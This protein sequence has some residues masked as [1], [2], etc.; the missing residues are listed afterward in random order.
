MST[1]TTTTEQPK[2]YYRTLGNTGIITSVF[3]FGFWVTFGVKDSLL[4]RE[5]IETA[6]KMLSAARSGGINL[7]DN[8][9]SRKY[10]WR[11]LC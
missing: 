11:G 5:G 4:D 8:A 10:L 9:G 7:F 1:T 2:M 3:G 6:K